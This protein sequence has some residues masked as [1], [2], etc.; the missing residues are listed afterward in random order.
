MI[1]VKRKQIHYE[2]DVIYYVPVYQ[3]DF[4]A[5]GNLLPSPETRYNMSEASTDPQMAASFNPIYILELR[6]HFDYTTKPLII[7]DDE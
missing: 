3:N 2:H 6:G 7:E 5:E 1:I 4:D